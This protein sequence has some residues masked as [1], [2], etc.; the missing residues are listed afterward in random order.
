MP[1]D[2][3]LDYMVWFH[4]AEIDLSV[5]KPGQ[6]VFDVMINEQNVSREDIFKQVG[7]FAA[8]SWYYIVRNLNTT[9]LSVKLVPVVGAPIICGVENYAIVTT[10]L[11]T[12]PDEGTY[13]G[14]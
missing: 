4:F 1:V 10:D 6:R 12:D 8:Y 2:A 9:T 14:I 5:N 11:S 13:M 7:S 3:R